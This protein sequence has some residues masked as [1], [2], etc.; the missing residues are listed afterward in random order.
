[1]RVTITD[2]QHRVAPTVLQMPP[3]KPDQVRSYCAYRID[4]Y[5]GT[6]PYQSQF[7]RAYLTTDAD[8]WNRWQNI[9]WTDILIESEE[10]V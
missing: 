9:P 7:D 2:L 10:N 6:N 5:K 1:M 3:L 8:L 4:Y